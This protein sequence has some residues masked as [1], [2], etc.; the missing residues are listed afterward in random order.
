MNKI[1]RA[2]RG[3]K[4]LTALALLAMGL[5]G[6]GQGEI[7]CLTGQGSGIQ[8]YPNV[9][10]NQTVN[11]QGVQLIIGNGTI[12]MGPNEKNSQTVIVDKLWS[13]IIFT[14]T[15]QL[16]TSPVSGDQDLTVQWQCVQ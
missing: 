2:S 10:E 6:C 14:A 13:R 8:S 4:N 15:V 1:E 12:G 16:K 7:N 3:L 11:F 5:S 9:T